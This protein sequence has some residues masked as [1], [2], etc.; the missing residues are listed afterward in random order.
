MHPQTTINCAMKLIA[1]NYPNI[2][3]IVLIDEVVS[4]NEQS[5]NKSLCVWSNLD[6]ELS[7]VDLLIALNPQG[8][9]FKNKFRV[10]PPKNKNTLCQ[11]LVYR[12]RNSFE[13]DSVIEH[14]K[15]LPNTSYL[16][17]SNDVKLD[18][19]NL[20]TG[21]TPLWLEEM[22]EMAIEDI[23]DHIKEHILAH[24]TVTVIYD[25]HGLRNERMK[26]IEQLCCKNGWSFHH[27]SHFFGC[28]DQVIILFEC[29]L[30]FELI[31]RGRNQVIFI[32]NNKYAVI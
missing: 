18:K 20:P 24:E 13:C 28:E 8:I 9:K 22:S 14:F 6:T 19:S 10:V 17:T 26:D 32:T 23:F 11:Q 21:R 7:N 12:H 4:V 15:I 2:H 25:K 31:S 3:N 29:S 5:T 1:K 27:Y 30:L 16:D